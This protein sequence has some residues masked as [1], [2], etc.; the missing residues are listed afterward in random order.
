MIHT[1]T[2]YRASIFFDINT[3]DSEHDTNAIERIC[4]KA[5]FEA[6]TDAEPEVKVSTDEGGPCW[7]PSIVFEGE[8]G[9]SVMRHAQ[10]I[11]T[12]AKR[13]KGIK[14]D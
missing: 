10:R 3:G 14:F 9:R 8:D 5:L 11:E 13:F 1:D 12:Y 7:G 6:R 2:V 4:D